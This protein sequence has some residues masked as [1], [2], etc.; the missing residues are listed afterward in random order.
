MPVSSVCPIVNT[1]DSLFDFFFFLIMALPPEACCTLGTTPLRQTTPVDRYNWSKFSPQYAANSIFLNI[2]TAL[3]YLSD[4]FCTPWF[5]Y[6]DCSTSFQ[7]K[8]CTR[9]PHPVSGGLCLWLEI[10]PGT[11]LCIYMPE[12]VLTSFHIMTVIL[13]FIFLWAFYIDHVGHWHTGVAPAK[14]LNC[15]LP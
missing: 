15:F 6:V 7:P 2:K 14:V 5:V 13:W 11:I 9:L 3:H 8:P 10:M 4:M 12:F 1:S